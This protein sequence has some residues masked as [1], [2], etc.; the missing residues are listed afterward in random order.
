[1]GILEEDM[2]IPVV[3]MDILEEDMVMMIGTTKI[4]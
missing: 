1:M 2:G 4:V 3:G